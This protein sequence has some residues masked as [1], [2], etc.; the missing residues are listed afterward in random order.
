M[1]KGVGK[2]A[3]DP[4]SFLAERFKSQ[5]SNCR[6]AMSHDLLRELK[7]RY[8][9]G[10]FELYLAHCLAQ[11][12]IG[13]CSELQAV[14]GCMLHVWNK[15]DIGWRPRNSEQLRSHFGSSFSKP[16]VFTLTRN[17]SGFR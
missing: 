13:D 11:L 8:G 9:R 1:G 15:Q 3:M 4:Y 5:P 7:Q 12:Y 10:K 16:D 2:E 17:S 14:L 6:E